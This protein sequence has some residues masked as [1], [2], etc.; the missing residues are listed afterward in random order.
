MIFLPTVI[1]NVCII[2]TPVVWVRLLERVLADPQWKGSVVYSLRTTET[3]VVY[4]QKT[5]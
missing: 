4:F 1:V 3:P 5:Q 2:P